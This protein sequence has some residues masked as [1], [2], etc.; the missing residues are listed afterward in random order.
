MTSFK[1]VKYHNKEY[2]GF[3][4][5]EIEEI[6]AHFDV[7]QIKG[8][9]GYSLHTEYSYGKRKFD[10]ALVGNFQEV[11]RAQKQGVPQLWK[12]EAWAREFASFIKSLL[13]G[14]KDPEIIE[15]HPPFSDYTT[16]DDF[17]KNYAVF[18]S[19]IL[20]SYPQ[21][22]ILIENRCGAR[23]TGGTFLLSKTPDIY[24]LADLVEKNKLSLKMA[25]DVPQIYTAHNPKND[26]EYLDILNSVK[27][28]RHFIGGVHLWG[29]KLGSTGRP[30]A[31]SGDLN[32][33]FENDK[34][35]N[36]FLNAFYE[37][38]NDDVIRKMV[39]EVNSGPSDLLSIINELVNVGVRFV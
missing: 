1:M 39:L 32:T 5:L 31:H 36:D 4:P 38:F 33:Y 37:L 24:K 19:I 28:A 11:I 22:E 7:K 14:H 25:Y 29:K 12:N 6:A 17:I 30:T 34:L 15:I 35:K 2:P 23:Y 18:E 13:E 21:V 8:K 3:I 20:D 9:L 10:F 27:D 26:K 16:L